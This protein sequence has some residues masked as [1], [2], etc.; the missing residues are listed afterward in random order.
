VGKLVISK[1]VARSYELQGGDRHAS[2][3][4]RKCCKNGK[5]LNHEEKPAQGRGNPGRESIQQLFFSGEEGIALRQPKGG[6]DAR[7]TKQ[8]DLNNPKYGSKEKERKGVKGRGG[9][10]RKFSAS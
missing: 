10:G 9:K 2:Q 8:N 7:R 3:G 5:A 1:R 6:R 4:K